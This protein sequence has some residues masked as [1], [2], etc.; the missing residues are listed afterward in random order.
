MPILEIFSKRRK[1]ARG[2]MPDVYTYD[3]LP[4]EF[5]VQIVHIIRDAL[6]TDPSYGTTY[7]AQA[8]EYIH[9]ALCREYGVFHLSKAGRKPRDAL[10]EF[11]L[12][13]RDVERALDVIEVSFQLINT[14]V[15][16][17][18][19]QNN[20][21]VQMKPDAALEELNGRFK[22][23]AIGFQFES[24]ELI[25][26]DSQ[27]LHANA[28]KPTL[29]L[30]REK[31]YEGANEEFLK[32]HEHYRHARYKECLVDALKAFESTMKSICAKRKWTFKSTD[33]AKTLIDICFDNG[34]VPAAL[35]SQFGSLRS[36]LESGT[37]TIRNK[38]GGHGQG[39]QVVDVPEHVARYA[40][41]LTAS[42]ILF[43]VESERS[44]K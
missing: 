34:L 3:S 40:L 10:V 28:V 24:G 21:N 27:L 4:E 36:L 7:A 9:D 17:W 22:E 33:T 31:I 29:T 42:S 14:Y 43:L 13:E 26:V 16:K 19:Y 20:T 25:R 12:A 8:Y 38:M 18:D 6:G 23:H 32:A 37:P 39:P 30:L 11:F 5:R 44:I 2:E 35:Q 15:R 41:N 1:R